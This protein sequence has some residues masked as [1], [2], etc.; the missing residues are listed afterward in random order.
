MDLVL[1]LA[2]HPTC[3]SRA[4]RQPPG[5]RSDASTRGAV[6]ESAHPEAARTQPLTTTG[7]DPLVGGRPGAGLRAVLSL[8]RW[9]C[10]ATQQGP[11]ALPTTWVR[12][13]RVREV[14][15]DPRAAVAIGVVS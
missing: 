9:H 7:Q 2:R 8:R 1:A 15:A 14:C 4:S 10:R 5:A 3:R 12:D 11:V 6:G 13:P